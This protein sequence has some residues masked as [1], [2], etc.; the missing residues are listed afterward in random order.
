M[1]ML[2]Q[3]T[4]A[5]AFT[6]AIYGAVDLSP[7]GGIAGTQ[8]SGEPSASP[9]EPVTR[10]AGMYLDRA[11]VTPQAFASQATHAFT[12]TNTQS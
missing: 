5:V 3:E 7:S 6:A 1:T 4:G 10:P 9:P 8:R 11:I 2:Q 12:F